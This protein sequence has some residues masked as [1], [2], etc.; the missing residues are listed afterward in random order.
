MD[1]P[2]IDEFTTPLDAFDDG[3]T[4]GS[5]SQAAFLLTLGFLL[6][7]EYEPG[8]GEMQDYDPNFPGLGPM[9]ME[10][11]DFWGI[12]NFLEEMISEFAFGFPFWPFPTSE[13]T[14]TI[15]WKA[16][17]LPEYG[18]ALNGIMRDVT[19]RLIKEPNSETAS[20]LI[21][22][23][24]Q[25]PNQLV[26]LC[27]TISLLNLLR[28]EEW[29]PV[30]G[31]LTTFTMRS[32][33]PNVR[34][35][36]S[37]VLGLV[38]QG[39]AS[40]PARAASATPTA[41]PPAPAIT[42]GPD[43]LLFHGTKPPSPPG[44]SAPVSQW[45]MPGQPFHDYLRSNQSLDLY[46]GAH[47]FQWEGGYRDDA[48]EI[49]ARNLY[50]WLQI[51]LKHPVNLIAHSHGGNVALAV[52]HLTSGNT[53]ISGAALD[54]RQLTLLSTPIHWPPYTPSP[55]RVQEVV[56]VRVRHDFVIYT[57][58][59]TVLMTGG[60][61]PAQRISPTIVA[62]ANPPISEHVIQGH[63]GNHFACYDPSIWKAQGINL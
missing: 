46:S 63:L 38:T 7:H 51:H 14:V 37:R 52:T 53:H 41:G 43:S 30:V 8:W 34:D 10:G 33:F 3:S 17:L 39:P 27:S 28:V 22:L 21:I 18:D 4:Q 1:Y 2:N 49:A 9:P 55:G 62:Q 48:R 58:Y 44:I 35:L 40:P 19:W 13:E 59:L 5:M 61:L 45:W 57:E 20:R 56:D 11:K 12:V 42:S 60:L 26:A 24:T 25:H 32:P 31:R 54:V 29:G 23:G 47:P 6:R 50:D 36:A 16:D 15:Y